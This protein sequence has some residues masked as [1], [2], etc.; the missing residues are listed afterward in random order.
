M[1]ELV[2][3]ALM[4]EGRGLEPVVKYVLV[5]FAQSFDGTDVGFTAKG[6]ASSF[7]ISE[8]Q[9]V[10]A[11]RALNEAGILLVEAESY[12]RG[13]PRHQYKLSHGFVRALHQHQGA[14]APLLQVIRFVLRHELGQVRNRVI[15]R[16]A[17]AHDLNATGTEISSTNNQLDK[18]ARARASRLPGRLTYTNRLLLAVLLCRADRFGV[19]RNVGSAELCRLTGLT[20]ARLRYRVDRLMKEGLIRA[21]VPG[22]TS[23]MLF[24]PTKSIYYLN[25]HHPELAQGGDSAKIIVLKKFVFGMEDEVNEAGMQWLDARTR[26]YW[27]NLFF[28]KVE[29]DKGVPVLQAKLDHYASLL[30]SKHRDE[31][32]RIPKETVAEIYQRIIRDFAS[33]STVASLGEDVFDLPRDHSAMI[34]RLYQLA[35]YKA[36]TLADS[37]PNDVECVLLPTPLTRLPELGAY[38]YLSTTLLTLPKKGTW[39]RVSHRVVLTKADGVTETVNYDHEQDMTLREMYDF[40][41]LTQG[42]GIRTSEG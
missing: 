31:F 42:S 38:V 35:R 26:P 37:V 2:I 21:Y 28:R 17:G 25:L 29:Q 30:L 36:V 13:R 5:R 24:K 39:G 34:A 16:I 22:A 4:H 7:G 23:S 11:M 32:N 9:S 6:V 1:D 18:L 41:L 8:S 19:V 12:G 10:K 27:D 33:P 15:E 3:A 40:G 20:K 14:E